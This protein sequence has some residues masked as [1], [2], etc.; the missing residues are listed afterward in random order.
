MK[1]MFATVVSLMVIII[2]ASAVHAQGE[3]YVQSVKA[4]VMSA[5]SFKAAVMGEVVKGFKFD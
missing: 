2:F 4:K 5:T 1:R 3:Y